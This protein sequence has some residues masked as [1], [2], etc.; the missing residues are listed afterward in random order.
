M[1][2]D[3][4]EAIIIVILGQWM[5]G[6]LL[7]WRLRRNSVGEHGSYFWDVIISMVLGWLICI[8]FVVVRLQ[9]YTQKL[10]LAEI[11]EIA[12]KIAS[13]NGDE[14]SNTMDNT[15]DN[16]ISQDGEEITIYVCGPSRSD[17]AAI[18]DAFRT[19]LHRQGI[20]C[21]G[22]VDNSG[23]KAALRHMME[24]ETPVAIRQAT[25]DTPRMKEL[26]NREAEDGGKAAILS[27][28]HWGR[29]LKTEKL[30]PGVRYLVRVNC[31]WY[32]GTFR[33]NGNGTWTFIDMDARTISEADFRH[34][35]TNEAGSS[36]ILEIYEIFRDNGSERPVDANG[37]A[38]N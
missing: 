4:I 23:F 7:C 5:L 24:M 14:T 27:R 9:E 2:R 3:M 38:I 21:A 26:M 37:Y 18:A 6:S 35:L 15:S 8:V 29:N 1:V 34:D 25:F 31:S 19:F 12:K 13:Q 28:I 22:H 10:R 32:T 30:S 20:P 16:T 33:M 17:K 36:G 11:A